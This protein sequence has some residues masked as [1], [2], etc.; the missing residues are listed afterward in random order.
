[1]DTY[2]DLVANED[3]EEVIETIID[4]M[5][6]NDYE[7]GKQYWTAQEALAAYYSEPARDGADLVKPFFH[8]NQEFIEALYVAVEEYNEKD[9]ELA[10]D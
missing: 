4:G 2:L 7:W 8:D 1:M 3:M 10:W 9:I 5:R 6:E